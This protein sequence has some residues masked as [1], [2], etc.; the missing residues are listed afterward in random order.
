MG[1]NS[2]FKGLKVCGIH[3]LKEKRTKAL[4]LQTNQCCLGY[5]RHIGEKSNFTSSFL[6]FDM[7]CYELRT[8]RLIS[9]AQG[10]DNNHPLSCMDVIQVRHPSSPPSLF[11][12]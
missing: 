8:L 7:T 9:I 11:S 4:N 6:S 10:L 2:A 5:H 3:I 12:F 1:F